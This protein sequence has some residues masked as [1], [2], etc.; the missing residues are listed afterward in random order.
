MLNPDRSAW[1]LLLVLL[2][3]VFELEHFLMRCIS[4]FDSW[5]DESQASFR[6]SLRKTF[7]AI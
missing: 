1:Q 7:V 4:L 6:E 2:D 5:Y 3:F